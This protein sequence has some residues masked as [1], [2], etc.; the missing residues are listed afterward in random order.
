MSVRLA[1]VCVVIATLVLC[2]APTLG[3]E[4]TITGV[5]GADMV[6]GDVS[7]GVT[8]AGTQEGYVVLKV[9]GEFVEAQAPPFSFVW[10]SR[11]V[12]DGTHELTVLEING[13]GETIDTVSQSVTVQNAAQVQ[14]PVTLAYALAPDTK[15]V[16]LVT[17]SSNVTE[18][19][20]EESQEFVPYDLYRSYSSD[21]SVKITETI[22]ANGTIERGLTECVVDFPDRTSRLLA[23]GQTHKLRVAADGT[24]SGDV[25]L[26]SDFAG[27]WIGL[28]ATPVDI[29]AT[30]TGPMLVHTELQDGVSQTLEGS[31]ELV[32][33]AT[34]AGLPCAI[35]K[36]TFA[37]RG[38]VTFDVDG[39]AETFADVRLAGGRTTYFA[40]AEGFV[41]RAESLVTGELGV[42]AADF[43]VYG[44]AGPTVPGAPV[45]ERRA[46][47]DELDLLLSVNLLTQVTP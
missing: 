34:E 24:I 10:N 14:A 25:E 16:Y 12:A 46:V 38:D 36:S 30:W 8:A 43:G 20:Q 4:L 33:F 39:S 3:V 1:R 22:L 17:G 26:G 42:A 7:L 23:V 35:I 19:G 37:L 40:V 31:H 47:P 15:R 41:V 5:G 2:A 29:G 6:S 13:D 27:T 44:V 28:P 11:A 9:D 32:G 21:L 45:G 18:L